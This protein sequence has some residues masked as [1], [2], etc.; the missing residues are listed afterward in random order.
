M[1]AAPLKL[2]LNQPVMVPWQ[3]PPHVNALRGRFSL[4]ATRRENFSSLVSVSTPY[5]GWWKLRIQRGRIFFRNFITARVSGSD[6]ARG[7][8]S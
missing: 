2:W 1:T 4:S 5:N 8:D 7:P 3:T 6:A